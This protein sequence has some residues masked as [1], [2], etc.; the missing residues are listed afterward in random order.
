MSYL[1]KIACVLVLEAQAT[2][3][4]SVQKLAE[5]CVRFTPKIGI[6]KYG[7]LF[8]E[9][10][11]SLNLFSEETIRARIII[12]SRR[13][14]LVVKVTFAEHPCV[15]LAKAYYP[16]F[17]KA[18]D[19]GLLPMDAAIYFLDP[20]V[21]TEDRIKKAQLFIGTM[22]RL[23]I[24]QF[25]EFLRL[26]SQSLRSRFGEI[27]VQIYS[28]AKG[29]A[30]PAW[31]GFQPSPTI[32]EF[33]ELCDDELEGTEVTLEP[34]LFSLKNLID[35]AMARLVGL[36]QRASQIQIELKLSPWS[37]IDTP[38]RTW[39]ISLAVAQGTSVGLMPIIRE[40]LT[41]EFSRHPLLAPARFLKFKILESVPGHDSQR[42]FFHSKEVEAESWD[43]L[44]GRLLSQLGEGHV[45][46][47]SL[48]PR[49][50]PEASWARTL[51]PKEKRKKESRRR[52]ASYLPSRILKHPEPL[53]L[54]PS[55]IFNAHGD[56]W[57]I[58]SCQGPER[59]S[60][61]WWVE[62]KMNRDYYCVTTQENE[63][64]WIFFD[65]EQHPSQAFLHGYFD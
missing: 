59:I 35:R 23:G 32:E 43:Q 15:S 48:I 52:V 27:A 5:A 1:K 60:A 61:E 13:L 4:E 55:F 62:K 39:T 42:D 36:G 2:P 22:R 19:F 34:L 40:K 20:F 56:F 26:P 41:Y 47:A 51:I 44:L 6:R 49:Y 31:R 38:L 24:R 28:Y 33:K 46:H 25:A 14:G 57:K 65:R 8:L 16:E 58:R 11:R 18:E 17:E 30:E 3:A 50:R 37:T 21:V 29:S 12:L 9:I 53:T 54:K 10:G 45:F 7:A 63:K 64:L